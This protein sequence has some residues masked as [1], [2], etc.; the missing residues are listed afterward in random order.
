MR[1]VLLPLL[2]L[3]IISC[4]TSTE[5]P[6]TTNDESLSRDALTGAWRMTD[7]LKIT[8]EGDTVDDDRVQY[9]MYVDGSVMWGFEAP[10]KYTE[11]YGYGTYYIDGDTLYETMTSGSWAFRQMISQNHNFFKIGI[12]V[13]ETSYTQIIVD[14]DAITY[15]SYERIN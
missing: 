8:N 9:K 14:D 11:W 6:E 13:K 4:Q 3:L 7:Y 10:E 15:E 1:N 12:D 5:T 2:S